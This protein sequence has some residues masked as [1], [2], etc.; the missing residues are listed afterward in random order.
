M[1]FFFGFCF[2]LSCLVGGV[3]FVNWEMDIRF[4]KFFKIGNIICD[5]DCLSFFKFMNCLKGIVVMD[6]SFCSCI[7]FMFDV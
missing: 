7:S 2:L 6:V 1:L 3:V 5:L 4:I